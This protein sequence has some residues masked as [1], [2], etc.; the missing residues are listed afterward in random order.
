MIAALKLEEPTAKSQP[1]TEIAVS[2]QPRTDIAAG[3]VEVTVS[4]D[5]ERRG[6]SLVLTSPR[7]FAFRTARSA[8]D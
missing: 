5:N 1:E 6:S 7:T 2:F 8:A 3:M 4:V